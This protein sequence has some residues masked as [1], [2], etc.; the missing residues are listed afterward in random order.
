M[1]CERAA[2]VEATTNVSRVI[3]QRS[4]LPA[5]EGVRLRAYGESLELTGYDMESG[6]TTSI[7]AVVE[8]EGEIVLPARLFLDMIRKMS[9]ERVL[10]R[11]GERCFTEV[12]C[13][14]AKFNIVGIAAGEF[15]EL[16]QIEQG[17]GVSFPQGVL[18]SMI[19]QTL[20]AVANTDSKPVHTGALFDLSEGLLNV[21]AV[22]GYRLAMRSEKVDTDQT[23]KF[24]VPGKL[25]GEVAKLLKDDA[26]AQ[27][28]LTVSRQ[29]IIFD[30]AGYMVI[31]RLL[32]GEFL[33]YKTSLPGKG[34]SVVNVATREMI[35]GIERTSLL[36]SDRLRSPLKLVFGKNE[37][38]MSCS[39]PLGNSYDRVDC[40]ITGDGVE[41]GFNNK[42]LM[43]A[44][45]AADTDRVRIEI[46]GALAPIKVLPPEGDGFLFLVLPVRLRGDG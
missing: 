27:V 24:V 17:E 29:H 35:E 46:S 3:A 25:L 6:I 34:N 31:S 2:L 43:D 23:M 8:N 13:G 14:A 40:E 15:P 1:S 16:P 45:K 32:V 39:T 4:S 20:F 41:M 44:L 18:R 36:I 9:G 28:S 21:V 5:L 33:D 37:I 22:D 11:V 19:E 7:A 26:E 12:E 42:Y 38:E 30:I 10:V